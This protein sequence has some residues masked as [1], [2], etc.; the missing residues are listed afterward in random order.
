MK[1]KKNKGW[2][3]RHNIWEIVIKGL[4]WKEKI[5]K[6]AKNKNKKSRE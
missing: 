3:R 6:K 1:N 4:N 5:N 2:I